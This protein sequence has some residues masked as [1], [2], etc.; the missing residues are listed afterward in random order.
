LWRTVFSVCLAQEKTNSFLENRCQLRYFIEVEMSETRDNEVN[1]VTVNN[2][3]LGYNS[4]PVLKGI[5]FTASR[6][7][8]LGIIGPNGSGKST[9]VRAI[10]RI[11]Q[12]KTGSIIINGLDLKKMKAKEVA[13]MVAV[14]P[15]NADFP[16]MITAFE[17]VLMG[18]TPHLKLLQNE[19]ASDFAVVQ[20]AMEATRT[21]SFAGRQIGKLSGGERQKVTIARALAQEPEVLL[22]DEP[23]AYLDIKHQGEI[24]NLAKQLCTEKNLTVIITLHDLNLAAQYCDRLIMLSSGRIYTEG[25]PTEVLTEKNIREVYGTS[26]HT[27]PHPVNQIPTVLIAASV[28]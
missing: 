7:R 11:I 24:L 8:I 21:S 27:F 16:K 22:L 26:V 10:S 14:V 5:S 19:G 17:L 15:Q 6:G 18:R 13:R 4:S 28:E 2:I 1:M 23:T 20:K 25:V 12:P 3:T 9:L